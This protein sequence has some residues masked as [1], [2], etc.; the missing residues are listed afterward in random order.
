MLGCGKDATAFPIGAGCSPWTVAPRRRHGLLHC[1]YRRKT[2]HQKPIAVKVPQLTTRSMRSECPSRGSRTSPPL[3]RIATTL[4]VVAAIASSSSRGRSTWYADAQSEKKDVPIT[5]ISAVTV[6]EAQLELGQDFTVNW[7]YSLA[8]GE[9]TTGDLTSFE[10]GMVECS[11]ATSVLAC[12]PSACSSSS[13]A[14]AVSLC[15]RGS[16]CLDSDG[17]YDLTVP[18]TTAVLIGKFFMLMVSLSSD[19]EILGCSAS[20]FEVVEAAALDGSGVVIST[21]TDNVGSDSGVKSGV[22]IRTLRVSAPAEG[23]TPGD[24]F[25]AA[26]LYEEDGVAAGGDFALD[27]YQCEGGA[28]DDGR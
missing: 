6:S 10:F 18:D 25:T 15:L 20:G 2:K 21:S 22:S 19:P 5:T 14:A 9:L 26:W 12:D 17:S 3:S 4:L 24:A 11:G 1:H 13:A 28:C 7:D 8:S 16:G 27:L 23:L